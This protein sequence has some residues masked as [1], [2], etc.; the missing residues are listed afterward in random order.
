MK[1]EA[2]QN[3]KKQRSLVYELAGESFD[4]SEVERIGPVYV[5]LSQGKVKAQFSLHCK[6]GKELIFSYDIEKE[7]SESEGLFS[8][9]RRIPF[10]V[11]D[12]FDH[13]KEV[14]D[15]VKLRDEVVNTWVREL[16]RTR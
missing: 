15:I 3:R 10:S 9:T 13:S 5:S 4:I 7:Y 11:Q 8:F 14:K 12:Y 2:W 16:R 6:S 1:R